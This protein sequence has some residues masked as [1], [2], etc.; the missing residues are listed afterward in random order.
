LPFTRSTICDGPKEEVERFV[1]PAE[2]TPRQVLDILAFGWKK[3]VRFRW[4]SRFTKWACAPAMP[5]YERRSLQTGWDE[6][7]A[8]NRVVP[9]K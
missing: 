7:R 6:L 2:P 4:I 3:I 9:T 5:E 8:Q 1:R